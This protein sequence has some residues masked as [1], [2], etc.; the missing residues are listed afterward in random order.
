MTQIQT[1]PTAGID[2]H[3]LPRDRTLI[4]AAQLDELKSSIVANGLR[5]PIEVFA[6]DA[7][8]GLLSGYRRL[9]AFRLLE[10]IHGEAFATIPALIRPAEEVC[11]AF[12]RVVEENDLRQD[13]SP[14]ERGRTLVVARES[15]GFDTLDAALAALYPHA[16]RRKQSRLRVLAEVVEALEDRITDPE[17]WSE[18]RLIR[19]GNILRLGWGDL[20]DAALDDADVGAEW[21]AIAPVIA[22]AESLPLEERATPQ[23]PK[24]LSRPT[25]GLRVRRERTKAGYVLHITGRRANDA[26]VGEVMDEIERW[27]GEG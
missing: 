19:L 7:G 26:V 6:A 13:L 20:I 25:Y 16:D 23:R 4:E 17:L 9:M 11:T 14:W 22:E 1:I 3:A 12:A 10:E 2:E 5:L 8:Y 21:D 15:V 24:R 18:N 27:F